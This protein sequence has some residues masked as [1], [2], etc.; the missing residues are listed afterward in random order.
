M[1]GAHPPLRVYDLTTG[2][3][4]YDFAFVAP[5]SDPSPTMEP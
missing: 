2:G 5:M 4:A 3:G 1:A